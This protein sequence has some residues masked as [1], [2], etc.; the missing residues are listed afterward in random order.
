MNRVLN[1]KKVCAMKTHVKLKCWS[2]GAEIGKQLVT[3]FE[4]SIRADLEQELDKKQS[5][6]TKQKGEYK[7]L[8]LQF[9]KEKEQFEQKT[10]LKVKEREKVIEDLK[11]KLDEARTRADTAFTSQQLAGEV[12]ELTLENA[13]REL[14]PEDEIIPVAKGKVG[15]DCIQVINVNG[16][17]IGKVIYESKRTASF[18]SAWISKLK[19]DNLTAKADISVIVTTAFPK[20][21]KGP[22]AII[23]NTW[24]CTPES[25]KDLSL[26]LRYGLLKLQAVALTNKNKETN[27]ELLYKFLTSEEFKNIFTSILSSLQ[28]LQESHSS[29]KVRIQRMWA[30]REKILELLLSQAVSFYG[31]IRA[32]AGVAIPEIKPLEYLPKAS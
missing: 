27:M 16:K 29:E 18:S 6:L 30:E 14:Y 22:F 26:V 9:A 5:E 11:K 1:L 31:N 19:V 15:A 2:C 7:K 12:Q 28:G 17:P 10:N 4:K 8:T 20:G 23:D 21:I 3:Q 24:L 25:V 13:L 32:I